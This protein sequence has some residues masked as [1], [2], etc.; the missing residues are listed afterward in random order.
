MHAEECGEGFEGLCKT[1][2]P[3]IDGERLREHLKNVSFTGKKMT[4]LNSLLSKASLNLPRVE[5]QA[6]DTHGPHR[7]PSLREGGPKA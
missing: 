7:N 6:F 5:F 4:N 1:M 3:P 2:R